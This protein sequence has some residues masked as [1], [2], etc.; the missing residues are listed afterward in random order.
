M[1]HQAR[2]T[3]LGEIA[4]SLAHQ[5]N[6]PLMAISGYNAGLRNMLKSCDSVDPR[7]L[8]ALDRQAEQAEHAGR[9]VHRI[10]DFLMRRTPQ[11]EPS[12]LRR[13]VDET[14]SL[15]RS[16]LRRR[17]VELD[18]VH[19]NDVPAVRVDPILL[20]QA[21]VNLVRNAVDVSQG[22]GHAPPR[23]EIRTRRLGP[24]SVCVEVR[25][26]G[27]GLRGRNI[28]ELSSPF[29]STKSDGMG[30]GLA[31]CRTVVE[32]H[33]GRL[34]ADDAPDGGARFRLVLPAMEDADGR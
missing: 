23:I 12:N 21:I 33:A 9:I 2:L 13:I 29:Y 15:L 24:G 25:D 27:A 10:R 18:L 5:L 30:L 8:A 31:I 20:G 34:E 7:I 28:E 26:H 11:P 16:D 14:A 4:S 32:A 3:S 22:L 1:A 17:G 6:Q 19:D